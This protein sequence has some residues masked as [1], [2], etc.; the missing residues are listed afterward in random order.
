MVIPTGI[1]TDS[2]TQAFAKYLLNGNLIQLY[3]F[4]NKEKIFDIHSSYRFALITM[5][6]SEKM[7][8]VFYA[9]QLKQL[10]EQSRHI[11]F[12]PSDILD[13]NP[14]TLNLPIIRSHRDLE[15]NRKIYL[16]VPIFLRN[17]DKGMC[18]NLWRIEF[19]SMF[20]M[21]NDSALFN[22]D[23]FE[24]AVPLYESKFIQQYDDRFATSDFDAKGKLI[25]RDVKAEEK[26]NDFEIRPRYWINKEALTQKWF[27]K[28]YTRTCLF[29]FRDVARATDERTLI[30]SV[31]SAE[32]G[33]GGNMLLILLVVCMTSYMHAYLL[34]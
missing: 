1:V 3:D 14:N 19:M 6:K 15:I 8:C 5:G 26:T 2:A 12:K 11:E 32:Y 4:E 33:F 23:P 13:M 28:S 29:G 18:D 25:V 16:H 21:A 10:E 30:T 20:H 22:E 9:H 27:D 7:D 17:I 31:Q 34:I 24:G